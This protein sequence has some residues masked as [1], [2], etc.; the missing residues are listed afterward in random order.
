VRGETTHHTACQATSHESKPN[1]KEETCAP[2]GARVAETLFSADAILVDQIYDEYAEERAQ[3]GDPICEG[4][5]YGYGVIRLVVW[6]VR[7]RGEDGGIEE[8]PDS[9]RELGRDGRADGSVGKKGMDWGRESR[10]YEATRDV[11]TERTAVL[12]KVDDT[13]EWEW[14]Q[15]DTARV[16]I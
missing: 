11:D 2:D 10:A 6:W 3:P 15:A 13:E 9:E 12:A 16:I 1:K 14:I 5:V 7:M 4:D 8:G